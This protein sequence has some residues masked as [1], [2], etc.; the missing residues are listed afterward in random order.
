MS[1]TS[2]L[3]T[4]GQPAAT[5]PGG[6]ASGP[7]EP[8]HQ[9]SDHRRFLIVAAIVVAAVVLAAVGYLVLHHGSS[10]S[11]FP[12]VQRA[13]PAQQSGTNGSATGNAAAPKPPRL[14]KHA[15]AATVRDPFKPLVLPPQ[16]GTTGA[17]G[18]TSTTTTGTTSTTTTPTTPIT[19]GTVP[20]VTRS[21]ISGPPK[22]VQLLSVRGTKSATFDLGYSHHRIRWAT[23]KA[24]AAGATK[25]VSFGKVLSLVGI[26]GG[27][28]VLQVGDAAPFTL[29]T[30]VA[31][32]V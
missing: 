30:G 2:L 26:H 15:V 12:P 20:S 7:E 28:V 24:P 19:T 11:D 31:H 22:W 6:A 27:S 23:V 18:S 5:P 1:E 3:P 13:T 32:V 10:G 4:L 21:P 29:T 9:P 17:A 25:G 14:H 8:D 16:A